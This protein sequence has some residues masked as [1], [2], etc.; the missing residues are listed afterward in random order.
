MPESG[1]RP[2]GKLI[3]AGPSP[4]SL[5]TTTVNGTTRAWTISSLRRTDLRH[6]VRPAPSAAGH[7][8]AGCFATIIEL[9][10]GSI[11]FLDS[12]SF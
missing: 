3:C 11:D 1:R 10:D 9:H 6:R 5:P 7:G 2:W 12:R 8:S 4:R